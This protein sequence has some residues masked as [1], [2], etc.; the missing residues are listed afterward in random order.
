MND[1]HGSE[2]TECPECV[3]LRA[4]LAKQEAG[5][6]DSL[7]QIDGLR[8]LVDLL[9]TAVGCF[10]ARDMEGGAFALYRANRARKGLGEGGPKTDTAALRAALARARDLLA[11]CDRD[12]AGRV[13][14]PLID[15]LLCKMAEDRGFG[16]MMDSLQRSWQ[17]RDPEGCFTVGPC[18]ASV[19][20][21][22]RAIDAALDGAA[23]SEEGTA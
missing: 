6:R 14:D 9:D 18:L 20:D 22:L 1:D 10:M 23:P 7:E 13:S 19:R 5:L 4:R 17:L 15:D 16:A 3:R 2:G 12:R 8:S 21:G 11:L